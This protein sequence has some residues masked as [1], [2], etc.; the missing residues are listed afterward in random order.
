MPRKPERIEVRLLRGARLRAKK[1]GLPFDISLEDIFIPKKCPLTDLEL[2]SYEGIAGKQGPKFNSPTLDRVLPE[3]GY[4]KGN[5]R[6]ISSL[7][8]NFMGS[9]TEPDIMKKCAIVFSERVHHYLNKERLNADI[10]SRYR[11]KRPPRQYDQGVLLMHPRR[12]LWRSGQLHLDLL[13][14]GYKSSK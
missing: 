2:K 10:D 4:I 1:K 11:D 12:R 14:G 8:N 7:A 9:E 5:V 13:G 3:L 6:V